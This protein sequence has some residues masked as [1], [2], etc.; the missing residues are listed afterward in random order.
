MKMKLNASFWDFLGRAILWGLVIIFT[1]GIGSV[2]VA[3]DSHKWFIE[4]IEVIK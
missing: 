3:Y 4:R 2:W 1:F